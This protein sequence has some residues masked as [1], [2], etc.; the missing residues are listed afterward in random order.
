MDI[1][2]WLFLWLWAV[3]LATRLWTQFYPWI[4]AVRTIGVYTSRT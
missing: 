2:P 1:Q 4:D 3:L